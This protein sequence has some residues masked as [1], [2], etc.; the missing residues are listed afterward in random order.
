MFRPLARF[1]ACPIVPLSR[2]TKELLSWKVALYPLVGNP[3]WNG[4]M[5]H[6]DRETCTMQSISAK[7][8]QERI[9]MLLRVAKSYCPN[10]YTVD[11]KQIRSETQ[12]ENHAKT[13]SICVWQKNLDETWFICNKVDYS[14]VKNKHVHALIFCWFP[15]IRLGSL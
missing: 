1:W 6:L 12:C 13:H 11:W 3:S 8:S 5:C 15:A 14:N 4:F 10:I 9:K 7:Y 2:T